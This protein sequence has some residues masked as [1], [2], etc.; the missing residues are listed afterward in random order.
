MWTVIYMAQ[1]RE[2]AEKLRELLENKGIIVK[3]RCSGCCNKDANGCFELLVPS[4]EFNEAQDIM[5]ESGL[6]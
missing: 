1:I 5:F 4:A 6:F 2:R 3:I